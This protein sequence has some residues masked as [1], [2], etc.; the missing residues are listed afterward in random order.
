MARP[1]PAVGNVGATVQ[2]AKSSA[3]WF[4]A[5]EWGCGTVV[6]LSVCAIRAALVSSPA[7][8]VSISRAPTS[9]RLPAKTGSPA[10]R[11]TGPDR[12]PRNLS[13]TSAAPVSTRPSTGTCSPVRTRTGCHS[14]GQL[15]VKGCCS[16]QADGTAGLPSAPEMPCAPRQLRL[17]PKH[18]VAALQPAARGQEARGR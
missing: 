5:S 3:S 15:G 14:E 9:S 17:V 7:R 4:K 1:A 13:S 11:R 16:R 18:K 10:T 2:L 8:S 12:P 6:S